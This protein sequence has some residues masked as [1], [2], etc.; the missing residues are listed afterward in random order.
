MLSKKHY[1]Y[2]FYRH[3]FQVSFN[4]HTHTFQVQIRHTYFRAVSRKISEIRK[5]KKHISGEVPCTHIHAHISS[6][7]ST[8]IL[9]VTHTHNKNQKQPP[10]YVA[11]FVSILFI[12]NNIVICVLTI[13]NKQGDT[14]TEIM[15]SLNILFALLNCMVVISYA[16]YLRHAKVFFFLFF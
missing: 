13:A 9:Q 1:V 7:V 3:T 5:F 4:R 6:T 16:N 14:G 12:I 8:H 2:G 11:A 10:R 15:V